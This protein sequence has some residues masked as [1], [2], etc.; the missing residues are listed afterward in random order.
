[1]SRV[2]SYRTINLNIF[3]FDVQIDSEQLAAPLINFGNM[4]FVVSVNGVLH[5][6]HHTNADLGPGSSDH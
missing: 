5:F 3:M 2:R 6:W 4:T 1:M